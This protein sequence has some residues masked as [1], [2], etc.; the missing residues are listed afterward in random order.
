MTMNNKAYMQEIV[1]YKPDNSHF[2]TTFE[3]AKRN[4]AIELSYVLEFLKISEL[5]AAEGSSGCIAGILEY[6]NRLISVVDLREVLNKEREIYGVDSKIVVVQKNDFIFGI[7][8][9]RL[10]DVMA[11]EDDKIEGI[12]YKEKE[13]Y[14]SGVYIENGVSYYI[15]NPETIKKSILTV[16]DSQ[17][18]FNVIASDEQSKKILKERKNELIGQKNY[19]LT[20]FNSQE[21]GIVFVVDDTKCYIDIKSVLRFHKLKNSK[22]IAVPCAKEFIRGL[23]SVRGEYVTVF[24]IK[25]F[26]SGEK[27]VINDDSILIVLNSSEFKMGILADSIC[28][29]ININY[30]DII[31][32]KSKR[33]ESSIYEYIK[34][35]EIYKIIDVESLLKDPN[36]IVV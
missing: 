13:N 3:V 9:D 12:P 19:A 30:E 4:Y 14:F 15:L 31:K 10:L 1:S 35:N 22:L 27:T 32:T 21:S 23:T 26:Y 28:E 25:N 29:D 34:D 8:C 20:N 5:D 16:S 2:F 6:R 11:V 17:N 33:A 7:I 18:K 24:D 36:L